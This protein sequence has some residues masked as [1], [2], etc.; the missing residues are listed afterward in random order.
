MTDYLDTRKD[1]RNVN[2]KNEWRMLLTESEIQIAIQKCAD[3][4]NAQF[5]NKEIVLACILKG[6]S[7]FFIELAK[8]IVIPNSWYFIEASS[9]KD[10]QQSSEKLEILSVIIPSKFQNKH[11]ILIDELFDN[12]F[13]MHHV[14]EQICLKADIDSNNIFCCALF[15]KKKSLYGTP[16]LFG[17]EVPNV[18]LVGFGLDDKQEKRGWTYLYACPK[19]DQTTKTEDDLLF[20]DPEYYKIIRKYLL[21]QLVISPDQK[22]VSYQ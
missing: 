5:E 1:L 11:V 3:Y 17:I 4:I 22:T 18:W 8:K 16:D 6:A 10:K 15:K 21:D 2:I 19:I 12:G 7:M 20:D 13:T 14:K 9:Y